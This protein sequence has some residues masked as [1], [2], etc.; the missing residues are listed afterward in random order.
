LHPLAP[1]SAPPTLSPSV[2]STTYDSNPATVLSQPAHPT[3]RL[4]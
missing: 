2:S 4:F 1:P 3:A